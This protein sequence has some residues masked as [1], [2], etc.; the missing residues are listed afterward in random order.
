MCKIQSR[1]TAKKVSIRCKVLGDL[2]F[3]TLEQFCQ[4]NKYNEFG[5]LPLIILDKVGKE[6]MYLGIHIPRLSIAYIT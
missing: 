1:D 4:V 3:V 5:R 2:I 6:R